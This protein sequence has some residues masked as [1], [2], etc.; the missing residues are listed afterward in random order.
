[1]NDII[2][3]YCKCGYCGRKIIVQRVMIGVSHT[4]ATCVTCGDCFLEKGVDKKYSK[5]NPK[6]AENI[7]KFAK[8]E[9][10]E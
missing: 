6:V 4:M 5:E 8:G 10:V 9:I 7:M 1:M 3:D 2:T